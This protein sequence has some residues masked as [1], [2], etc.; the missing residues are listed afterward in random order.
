MKDK[1][2]MQWYKEMAQKI[3]AEV[4]E[5]HTMRKPSLVKSIDRQ[6]LLESWRKRSD[7]WAK[8]IL[9]NYIFGCDPIGDTT[10]ADVFMF[11]KK[12]WE[13]IWNKEPRPSPPQAPLEVSGGGR[14]IPL[15]D[16]LE[17]SR[18]H[19]MNNYYFNKAMNILN[20]DNHEKS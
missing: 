5:I 11:Q 14:S 7:A 9:T 20:K 10:I 13:N 18:K 16:H 15:F 17:A 2:S 6:L 8:P 12:T 3:N 4:S 19:V 1:G